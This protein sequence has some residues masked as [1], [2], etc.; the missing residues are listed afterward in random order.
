MQ[1]FKI[2]LQGVRPIMF[3]RYPGDNKSKLSP[4]EKFYRNEKNQL[5]I[6]VMNIYSLL[7]SENGKSASKQFGRESKKIGAAVLGSTDIS[8]FD[9]NDFMNIVLT[10]NGEPITFN[11]F[12][13]EFKVASYVARVKGGVPNPVD[14][15]VYFGTWELD[16]KVVLHA[17][18]ILKAKGLHN[19][20]EL[21]GRIGL[22]TFRPLYGQ[23]KVVSFEEI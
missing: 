13:T 10:C 17:D 5:V 3:D 15:P 11:G 16:I 4:E 21:A 20:F 9:E 7:G 14:R 2:K 18:P 22:G 6:P 23:F 19:L 1:Q 8:G 12:G